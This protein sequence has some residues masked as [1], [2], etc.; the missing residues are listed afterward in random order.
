M[1]PSST[2]KES[3]LSAYNLILFTYFPGNFSRTVV[4]FQDTLEFQGKSDF[5][6]HLQHEDNV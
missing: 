2:T 5:P 3:Q 6:G 1:K 4:I